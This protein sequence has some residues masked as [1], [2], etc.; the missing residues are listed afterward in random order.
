MI[1]VG[2]LVCAFLL[3]G[4][5]ARGVGR[6]FFSDLGIAGD[7]ALATDTGVQLDGGVDATM[8]DAG[9]D[10]S[11]FDSG[12][13]DAGVG[14]ASLVDSGSMDAGATDAGPTDLGVVDTGPPDTGPI[15]APVTCDLCGTCDSNALNDCYLC[16][17][18]N[19]DDTVNGGTSAGG[20]NLYLAIQFD[21]VATLK[22]KRAEVFTGERTGSNTLSIWSD[23]GATTPS[24][25]LD[26][27]TFALETT[28]GWQGVTFASV[29]EFAAGSF[30]WIV[31]QPVSGQQSS[32]SSSGESVSYRGAFGAPSGWNGPYSGFMKLR[33]YCVD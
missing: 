3:G 9:A 26:T 27:G 5:A 10:G 31:W 33:L 22:V 6:D 2:V 16:G 14:D 29:N 28:N 1:R 32:A 23:D 7:A 18:S 11:A 12:V 17:A 13:F 21:A 30:G 4:C 20:P 15:D 25:M 19:T 8:S 24:A